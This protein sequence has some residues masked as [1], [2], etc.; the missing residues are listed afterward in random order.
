MY[1]KNSGSPAPSRIISGETT[2]RH[3]VH[4]VEDVASLAKVIMIC[5][6]NYNR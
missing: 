3:L 4:E 2:S 6:N 1:I 5:E